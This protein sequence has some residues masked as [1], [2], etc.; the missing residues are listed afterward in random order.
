MKGGDICPFAILRGLSLKH[1]EQM[2]CIAG[3]FDLLRNT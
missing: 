3:S 1:F 2:H